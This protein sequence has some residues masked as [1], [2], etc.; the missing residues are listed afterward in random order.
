MDSLKCPHCGDVIGEGPGCEQCSQQDRTHVNP[1]Q[2]QQI[3]QRLDR[4]ETH[5]R[6]ISASLRMMLTIVLIVAVVYAVSIIVSMLLAFSTFNSVMRNA[7]D[8]SIIQ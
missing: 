1:E 3:N 7:A 2:D 8:H 5:L 6:S 4:M